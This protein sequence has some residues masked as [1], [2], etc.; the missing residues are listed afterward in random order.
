VAVLIPLGNGALFTGVAA[1]IKSVN[2]TIACIAVQAAGAPAMVESWRAKRTIVHESIATIADGIGVRV[3]VPEALADFAKLADDALLVSEGSLRKAMQLLHQHAG[4][5]VEPSGAA[6]IAALLEH[7][8]RF[9][10]QRVATILCGG[11][12]TEQQ[13]KDWKIG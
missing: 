11:N 9:A 7:R 5:V 6:G 13:F 4:L 3:P 10:G 8:E 2:P 1:A 12:V